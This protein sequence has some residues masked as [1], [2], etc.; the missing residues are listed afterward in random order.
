V[1]R[2]ARSEVCPSRIVAHQ[3]RCDLSSRD[4][5]DQV[6]RNPHTFSAVRVDTARGR[7]IMYLIN[8][9]RSFA[10]NEEGQDLI[11]YAML[12]ALIA[13]FCVVAVTAAGAK[14]VEVFNAIVAA[15]PA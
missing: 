7:N 13:L 5:A 14:V 15:I 3:L 10:R 1:W 8:H 9:L 2:F 12:V 6:D 11:E 4:R